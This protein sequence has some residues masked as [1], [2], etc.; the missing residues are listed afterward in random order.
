MRK[1]ILLLIIGLASCTDKMVKYIPT[2]EKKTLSEE[3]SEL[4][5]LIVNHWYKHKNKPCHL[6]FPG[7]YNLAYVYKSCFLKLNKPEVESLLG[8]PDSTENN[9]YIY[10]IKKDCNKKKSLTYMYLEIHFS[11]DSVVDVHSGEKQI[12]W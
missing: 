10:V 8:R 7:S 5:D 1:L 4:H 3:C 9:K 2:I 6:A 11:G 12:I